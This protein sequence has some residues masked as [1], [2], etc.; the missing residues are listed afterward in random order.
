MKWV[1]F[2]LFLLIAGCTQAP[3][4]TVSTTPPVQ[5]IITTLPPMTAAPTTT[6]PPP[7]IRP[8][9]DEFILAIYPNLDEYDGFLQIKDDAVI[10][11]PEELAEYYFSSE[12]K[13]IKQK[14]IEWTMTPKT[15]IGDIN[16]LINWARAKTAYDFEKAESD[17]LEFLTAGETLA[18]GKGICGDQARLIASLLYNAGFVNVTVVSADCKGNVFNGKHGFVVLYHDGEEYYID[19]VNSGYYYSPFDKTTTRFYKYS[20]GDVYQVTTPTM[21]ISNYLN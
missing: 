12:D 1:L 5:T 20:C 17:D 18:S 8:A 6:P 4:E 2:L 19:I 11:V 16:N 3:P 21:L 13:T 9:F 7:K 14:A 10:R 15:D